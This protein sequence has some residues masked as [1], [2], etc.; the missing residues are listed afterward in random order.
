MLDISSTQI[1]D[2]ICPET[3][4]PKLAEFKINKTKIAQLPPAFQ[5]SNKITNTNLSSLQGFSFENLPCEN[6]K[7]FACTQNDSP[8]VAEFIEKMKCLVE[9]TLSTE[10]I[11]NG[12]LSLPNPSLLEKVEFIGSTSENIPIL[13]KCSNLTTLKL[14]SSNLI[15]IPE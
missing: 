6:V 13:H 12:S 14:S 15:S 3:G 11:E 7:I 4:L 1:N 2:I 9:L 5:N 8:K 10:K